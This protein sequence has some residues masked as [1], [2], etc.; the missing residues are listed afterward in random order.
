[1]P[2]MPYQR[3]H[4]ETSDPRRS[5]SQQNHCP[6][7]PEVFNQKQKQKGKQEIFKIFGK[8]DSQTVEHCPLSRVLVYF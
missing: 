5:Q 7:F 8:K 6:I 4:S 1:M 2:K 3:R